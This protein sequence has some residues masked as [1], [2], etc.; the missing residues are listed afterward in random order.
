MQ[1]RWWL[2]MSSRPSLTGNE[3]PLPSPARGKTSNRTRKVADRGEVNLRQKV[4]DGRAPCLHRRK[5][6]ARLR[7]D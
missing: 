5:P 1:R 3:V 7:R 4:R 2:R 6:V